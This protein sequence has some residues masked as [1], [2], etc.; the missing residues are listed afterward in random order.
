MAEFTQP[1]KPKPIILGLSRLQTLSMP[2]LPYWAGC[3]TLFLVEIRRTDHPPGEGGMGNTGQVRKHL[4]PFHHLSGR[5]NTYTGS[6]FE[7]VSERREQKAGK[8]GRGA[9]PSS[10]CSFLTSVGRV[11]P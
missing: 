8:C 9:Q 3:F 6:S 4:D 11:M 10:A 7:Q 1:T 2:Q 5:L